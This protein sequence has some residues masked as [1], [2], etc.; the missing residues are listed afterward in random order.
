[1]TLL[2]DRTSAIA[3]ETGT[4]TAERTRWRARRHIK[5]H[6]YAGGYLLERC[7]EEPCLVRPNGV[8]T[9]GRLACPSCGRGSGN[10]SSWQLAGLAPGDH[11]ACDCGHMW[12]PRPR[13]RRPMTAASFPTPTQNGAC[14]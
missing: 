13:E 2:Q 10:L 1:M 14:R 4:P 5:V 11:V 7:E 9:C 3:D 12:I 6:P 8:A